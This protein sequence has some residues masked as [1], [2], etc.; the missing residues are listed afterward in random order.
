[1]M[2][3]LCLVE[4]TV[5]AETI[6]FTAGDIVRWMAQ[7]GDPL[8]NATDVWG[9]SRVRVIPEVSYGGSIFNGGYTFN[10]DKSGISNATVSWLVQSDAAGNPPYGD[11]VNNTGWHASFGDLHLYG[12]W[13]SAGTVYLISDLSASD[14]AARFPTNFTGTHPDL[15]LA[16][17]PDETRFTLNFTLQPGAFWLN[18]GFY[19]QV[20]GNWYNNWYADASYANPIG[21][22]GGFGHNGIQYAG[23]LEGNMGD[24]YQATVVPL[25]GSLMLMLS[26]FLGLRLLGRKS[27]I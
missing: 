19:F 8:H 25:P 9:I 17:M 24:G 2:T 4:V 13:Y 14:F 21:F 18:R 11:G 10:L 12:S 7:Q 5:R 27:K 20:D 26:G 3:C 15:P 16:K 1:M 23:N 6:T 22:T